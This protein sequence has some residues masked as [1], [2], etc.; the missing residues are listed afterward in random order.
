MRTLEPANRMRIGLMGLVVTVLVVGVGQT[1]T[2]VPSCSLSPATTGS[3]PT[4]AS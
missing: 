4:P 1:F 3:S 2:S